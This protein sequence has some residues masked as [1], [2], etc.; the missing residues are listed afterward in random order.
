MT[1]V[2]VEKA[3]ILTPNEGSEFA[4]F[5]EETDASVA[6][7]YVSGLGPLIRTGQIDEQN[8]FSFATHA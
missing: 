3:F 2:A 1:S 5:F 4:V 6:M 7:V 8:E